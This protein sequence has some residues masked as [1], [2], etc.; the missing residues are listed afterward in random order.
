MGAKTPV[1][2]RETRPVVKSKGQSSNQH[3]G[4]ISAN[5]RDNYI[6]KEKFLGADPN[7]GGHVFEAKRNRSEQVANSTTGNDIVKAQVGTECDP[8]ILESLEKEVE[9]GPGEPVPATKEGG[10]M[11][12]I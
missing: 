2:D 7:L 3:E 5:H 12:K 9:I 4:R 6:E 8:F 11:S 1:E 10:F